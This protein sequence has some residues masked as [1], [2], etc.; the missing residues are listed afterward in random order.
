MQYPGQ[1]LAEGAAVLMLF[2][3]SY[4][5]YFSS[6]KKKKLL[7]NASFSIVGC[8]AVMIAVTQWYK[9]A[10]LKNKSSTR[11]SM[12]TMVWVVRPVVLLSYF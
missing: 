4:V 6:L 7:L 1:V 5:H 3:L 10:L 2:S 12:G 8:E 11:E 9:K